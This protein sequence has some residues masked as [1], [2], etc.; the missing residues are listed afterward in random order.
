MGKPTSGIA[1]KA[2]IV[3]GVT[4]DLS[5]LHPHLW[6]VIIPGKGGKPDLPLKVNVTYGL[7]CFARDKLPDEAVSNDAWYEDS[8]EKR[9]FCQLRWDLSKQLPGI[10][11][12]LGE[13]RC[14]NTGREEF[15]TLEVVHQ[16]RTFEYAVFFTVTKAKKA[17]GAHLNLFVNSAHERYDPLV[18]KKPISFKFILLNRY[19]GKEIKLPS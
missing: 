5:H 7:H 15:V 8:R 11:S 6:E 18:Y 1:W 17:D 2:T 13:R 9:V 16:G 14:I 3:G 12:T 4:Y 19:I 10:V